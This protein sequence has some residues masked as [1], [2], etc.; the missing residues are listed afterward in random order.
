MV[1]GNRHDGIWVSRSSL[2][3]EDLDYVNRSFFRFFDDFSWFYAFLSYY[4][5]DCFQHEFN[6]NLQD[7]RIVRIYFVWIF[8]LK[9][10]LISV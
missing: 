4:L 3:F 8:F 2:K 6:G 10:A 1:L 7:T 5:G 9:S